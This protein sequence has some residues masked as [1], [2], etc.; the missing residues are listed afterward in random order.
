MYKNI[1]QNTFIKLYKLIKKVMRYLGKSFQ[2]KLQTM[3]KGELK[4]FF[5]VHD[6]IIK[7]KNSGK[8]RK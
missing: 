5:T 2:R 3:E 6:I 1:N 4:P 7:K 8:I